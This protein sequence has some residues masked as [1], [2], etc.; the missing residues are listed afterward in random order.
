VVPLC[1]TGGIVEQDPTSVPTMRLR[2]RSVTLVVTFCAASLALL[3]R[4]DAQQPSACR[5]PSPFMNLRAR[6]ERLIASDDSL[7]VAFRRNYQLPH[8]PPDSVLVVTDERICT[9]AARAYYRDTIGPL[10]LGGVEVLRVGHIYVVYAPARG[11]NHWSGL[12]F[13]TRDFEF[14]SG[15]LS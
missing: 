8:L 4:L 10:P 6:V 5:R 15:I 9:R 3:A 7:E 13:F 12:G 2:A 1:Y 14:I 11:F